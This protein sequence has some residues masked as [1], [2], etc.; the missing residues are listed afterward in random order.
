MKHILVIF[1]LLLLDSAFA[2]KIVEADSISPAD[3]GGH[4]WTL[5]GEAKKGEVV[6]FRQVRTKVEPG[7]GHDDVHVDVFDQV[8]YSPNKEVRISMLFL[9]L[10]FFIHPDGNGKPNWIYRSPSSNGTI[11]G[12]FA[13]SNSSPNQV[14]I[15]FRAENGETTEI[16]LRVLIMP[17]ADAAK[18]YIGPKGSLP[19]MPENGE[20]G[21]C[22]HPTCDPS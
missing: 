20:W 4:K 17:Y 9:D 8:H 13:G 22:G 7:K 15:K 12:D 16:S 1:S 6:I 19:P 5:T 3:L 18:L 10:N 2:Q 21:W 11:S 14:T